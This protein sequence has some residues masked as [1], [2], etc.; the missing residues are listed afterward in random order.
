MKTSDLQAANEWNIFLKTSDQPPAPAT[1]L[2]VVDVDDE[3]MICGP[4]QPSWT[5]DRQGGI[6]LEN[7]RLA[8]NFEHDDPA[9]VT[10]NIYRD[11]QLCAEKVRK[12][13][14]VDPDSGDYRDTV[15]AY[16][17]AA[18]DTRSGNVS[19][20][21]PAHSFRLPEQGQVIPAK[22]LRNRGGN[23]IDGHHF[24]NWGKP[25]DELL[26]V[27]TPVDRRGCYLIR[28]EFFQRGGSG[29]HGHRLRR[30]KTGGQECPG[31]EKPWPPAF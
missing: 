4:V 9:N 17:V 26:T 23:L 19:H 1:P 3:R 2:R 25:D 10:M 21:T 22:S 31:R 5:A 6:T 8:L 29:Q 14:W 16:R 20:L 12:M 30:E 18:V 27:P 24:E 13:K 15:H 7:D 28:A 11:G